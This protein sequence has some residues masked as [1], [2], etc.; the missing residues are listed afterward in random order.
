MRRRKAQKVEKP[1]Y[2]KGEILEGPEQGLYKVR[3]DDGQVLT[4]HLTDSVRGP[5]GNMP[6]VGD[7]IWAEASPY[8]PE[9][10]RIR[11]RYGVIRKWP[12]SGDVRK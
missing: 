5:C 12:R 11:L 9:R 8:D 10:G 4:C 1:P 7:W 2:P 6:E 3:L